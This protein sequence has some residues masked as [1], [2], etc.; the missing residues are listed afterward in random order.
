MG[1]LRNRIGTALKQAMRDKDQITLSTLRLINAA[2]KDRD[3]AA[4]V[5]GVEDGVSESEVQ[6]ILAKM[7]KQRRESVRAYEEAGRL[8]L[9]AQEEAEIAVIEGFLPR[10]LDEKETA[11]AIDAAIAATG[12]DSIRDMGKVMGALKEAHTG[13]LDFAKVGALVKDRLCAG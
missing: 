1:T 5:E 10:Q 13:Q 11:R 12:A 9:A 6:K 3:I 2:I 7:V 4:R 8:E